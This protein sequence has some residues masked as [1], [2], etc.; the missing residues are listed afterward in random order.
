MCVSLRNL[1]S[2]RVSKSIVH[3]LHNNTYFS[4]VS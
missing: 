3:F 2:I 4:N 1:G